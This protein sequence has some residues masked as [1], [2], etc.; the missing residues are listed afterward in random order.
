LAPKH[1]W[2]PALA[3]ALGAALFAESF[4]KRQQ[5]ET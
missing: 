3:V 1:E 2:D 4:Y 5:S